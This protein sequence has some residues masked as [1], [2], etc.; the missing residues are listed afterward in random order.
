V[1]V[2]STEYRPDFIV[3]DDTGKVLVCPD[4]ASFNA[5]KHSKSSQ[6]LEKT[7]AKQLWIFLMKKT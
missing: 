6:G 5:I 3:K 7:L 2:Y 4:G 1:T